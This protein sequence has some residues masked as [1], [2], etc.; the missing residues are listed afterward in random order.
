MTEKE[1]RKLNR[2]DLL[3]MLIMQAK[4]TEELQAQLDDTR[5]QLDDKEITVNNAGSMAEAALKLNGIFEAADAAAAQYIK[6]VSDGDGVTMT[7]PLPTK[8]S[9]ELMEDARKQAQ[10]LLAETEEKCRAREEKA[11]KY[12]EAVNAKLK[13]LYGDYKELFI[14]LTNVMKENSSDKPGEK[15]ETKR[16]DTAPDAAPRPKNKAGSPAE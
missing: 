10:R 2:R 7:A 3:E 13:Q 16:P 11:A 8:E 4:R 6:S 9:E 12:V 14:L 5:K 1:L 15:P